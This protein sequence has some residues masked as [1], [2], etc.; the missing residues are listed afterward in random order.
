MLSVSSILHMIYIKRTQIA[1]GQSGWRCLKLGSQGV[2]ID[3]SFFIL[4]LEAQ[5]V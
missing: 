3:K 2:R 1:N 4:G 5:E